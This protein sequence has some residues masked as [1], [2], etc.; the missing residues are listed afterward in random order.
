MI[1]RRQIL[2]IL[3]DASNGLCDGCLLKKT[4]AKQRPQVN[5]ICRILSDEDRLVREKGSLECDCCGKTI[6]LNRL[7]PVPI[8]LASKIAEADCVVTVNQMDELRR[9]M[10]H[11]LNYLDPNN[12]REGFSKRV[13]A[14]RDSQ[15]IP[16]GIASLM[17]THASYRNAMYYNRYTLSN[18][19]G[20]ILDLVSRYLRSYV[21]DS[22]R[23]P[24][25][26]N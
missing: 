17:L 26:A 9:E 4:G 1:L 24:E 10:I 25:L 12:S 3:E 18:D 7:K 16:T 8:Q 22:N 5:N 11:Y 20:R 6:Y 21:K 13:L 15:S 23:S 19:E 2:D 14:L